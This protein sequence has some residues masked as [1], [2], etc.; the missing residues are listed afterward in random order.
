MKTIIWTILLSSIIWL[1]SFTGI[2]EP[3]IETKAEIKEVEVF[4]DRVSEK[5][6]N[7]FK[8][9][10]NPIRD[11]LGEVYYTSLL[12]D[13]MKWY[14]SH[15]ST[16]N[17]FDYVVADLDNDPYP[18]LVSNW[19]MYWYW[20]NHEPYD[21]L[22]VGIPYKYWRLKNSKIVRMI[23]KQEIKPTYLHIARH[24]KDENKNRYEFFIKKYGKEY[25]IN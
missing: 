23:N 4:E 14:N 8:Y 18:W 16:L 19:D 9:I 3:V 15:H 25:E 5:M 22:I 24:A 20:F 7:I 17:Y 2:L 6:N 1:V 11:N 13:G 12:R 21:Q 10:I